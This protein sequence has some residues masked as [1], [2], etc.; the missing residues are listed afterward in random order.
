MRQ[1][2]LG[3]NTEAVKTVNKKTTKM[4]IHTTNKYMKICHK[5]SKR[6]K[7][8]TENKSKILK[9]YWLKSMFRNVIT[10]MMSWWDSFLYTTNGSLN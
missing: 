6:L 1:K 9:F 3:T 8:T 10:L 7:W 4:E 2:H 5:C